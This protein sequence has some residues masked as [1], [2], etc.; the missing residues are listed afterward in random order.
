MK[1]KYIAALIV[2]IATIL[3]VTVAFAVVKVNVC[4]H[5]NSPVNPYVLIE[6][7]VQS[8]EDA[9]NLG[10]HGQHEDDAWHPYEYEGVIYP[11]RNE[12]VFGSL[13]DDSCN[14]IVP[15]SP[16]NTLAPTATNTLPAPTAT[17]TQPAPT[18]TFTQLPPT[19]TNTLPPP[20][21]TFTQPPPTSTG[22]L[23]PPTA[24]N[25]QPPPTP[26]DPG[27]P[28][29]TATQPT[30]TATTP[31]P[32][33]TSTQ[34]LP[35]S[36]LPAPTETPRPP[37]PADASAPVTY[38]GEPIGELIA[39]GYT[40]ELYQGVNAQDGTLLLPSYHKGAALYQGVIWV[41]RLWAT[42]WLELKTDDV[43]MIK[44]QMYK[45]T[46]FDYINYGV[47]PKTHGSGIQ[48]IATCYSDDNGNW[49][50]V[51]LY[52]LEVIARQLR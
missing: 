44:G 38:P 31:P 32:T 12:W 20:T 1:K 5:T 39:G 29:P 4:H 25:T 23:P 21:S 36:T 19:A 48:F 37:A 11:G 47:Y 2:V 16:T 45:V 46:G 18:S 40:Y 14:L 7:S 51:Q 8:V 52:K 24:T 30:A 49:Q 41:H 33:A 9:I 17:N 6:V 10:G 42:G 28:T 34:P 35:T 22:T 15:P 43:I 26:T 27:S 3:T 50:G 13:I